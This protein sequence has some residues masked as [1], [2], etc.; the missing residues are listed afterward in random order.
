MQVSRT[1]TIENIVISK[2]LP[3]YV[4]KQVNEAIYKQFV[5]DFDQIT[6]VS[7]DL[8]A[9]LKAQLGE[10]STLTKITG[11]ADEQ[12]RKILFETRDGNRIEAVLMTFLPNDQRKEKR[13]SLCVST[14]CGCAM[15]CKFCATGA[16][17]FKKN[18]S[19]DE[20]VDQYLYFRQN[21][22]EVDSIVV[23]GMGEPF[24]NPNFFEALNML[25]SRDYVG[26]ASRKVSVSTV[27]II[28]GIRVLTENFPQVN[29][30]FSLHSP[31]PEQRLE[32]MP[33]TK[34]YPIGDV[35][36]A[37]DEHIAKTNR[38]VF[39]AYTM[40]ADTN[41]SV[42]HAKAL[43]ALINKK[44]RKSYLYHVN[45]IRFH[46]ASSKEQ[47]AKP[48]E[49]NVQEFYKILKANHIDVTIRQSFGLGINAACGQLNAEYTN[50]H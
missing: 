25:V 4:T 48:E 32:L 19:A 12:S 35:M 34:A 36:Q 3:P 22:F 27:G 50:L 38:K 46:P 9:E 30:T 20:I 15:G 33:I 29:V 42:V 49:Q 1:K 28:P 7:K 47:F 41:D 23:M 37:L 10:V 6:N 24:A 26:L 5:T 44:G 18:L 43:A 8:R 21:G 17:G 40:L 13:N 14:Q 31:F 2:G 39:L 16:M 45:L 11:V